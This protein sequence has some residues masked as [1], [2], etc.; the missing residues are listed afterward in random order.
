MILTLTQNCS[1]IKPMSGT[2][3]TPQ[4]IRS[5]VEPNHN[6]ATP[7][8][9]WRSS[10]N[11]T[12]QAWTSRRDSDKA[13]LRRAKTSRFTSRA[14]TRRVCTWVKTRIWWKGEERKCS[15]SWRASRWEGSLSTEGC[16]CESKIF[17]L[18]KGWQTDALSFAYL[19][20]FL[21]FRWIIWNSSSIST[22]KA[23]KIMRNKLC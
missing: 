22:L 23:V 13:W 19:I 8:V 21:S 9:E 3:S 6:T 2:P 5:S 15:W 10:L 12:F 18:I 16:V 20:Y 7:K 17:Q 1:A 11:P 4:S 14:T